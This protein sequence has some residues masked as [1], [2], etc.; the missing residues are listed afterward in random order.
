MLENKKELE[1]LLLKKYKEKK[2]KITFQKAL[3]EIKPLSNIP[4]GKEIELSVLESLI[5]KIT[6]KWQIQIQWIT[7]NF[8]KA[9]TYYSAGVK[10]TI[11]HEWLGDVYAKTIYELY[12]KIVIKMYYEIKF[13]KIEKRE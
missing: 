1:A 6:K 12:I 3:R 8:D 10:E 9:D 2:D 5:V 11:N 4:K 7:P 13:M